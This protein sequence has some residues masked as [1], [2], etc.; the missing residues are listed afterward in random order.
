M[1]IIGQPQIIK[2]YIDPGTGSM[3]F[4]V[5]IGLISALVYGLRSLFIKLKYSIGLKNKGVS[6]DSMPFVIYSEGSRYFNVFYS[7]CEEFE[8]RKITLNYLTQSKDDPIFDQHFSYVKPEFIGSG[9]SGFAKLNLLKANVLLS[10]T[11]GLDVYQWKKSRDVKHY[12]H[13]PHMPNDITTYRMFGLDYYD[14]VLVSGEYQVEQLKKLEAIRNIKKKEIQVVGLTYL[15]SLYSRYQK[16]KNNIKTNNI[17]VLLAPS[18]GKS[19]IFSKY[20]GRIIDNLLKTGFDIIIRPHPQ[21]YISEKEML[22]DLMNQYP[23]QEHLKWNRDIDNFNVLNTSD[24][25][26]SDF[27]GV[28]FDFS[29]VFDKPIIYADTSFDYSPYDAWWLKEPL[30]TFDVLPKIG[31]KLDDE[32]IDSI[33]EL[34]ESTLKDKELKKG[35]TEARKETWANKGES[36][37]LIADY[38][39]EK[40]KEYNKEEQ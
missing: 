33:K 10:T 37:K 38:M 17:T 18:W 31:N 4:T 14:A 28:I 11:P 12:I 35:R 20:G 7:I 27:S 5:L 39:I 36:A 8:K 9:N 23:E 19:S 1:H 3:L 6:N 32:N 29:L 26:I 13:I 2:A 24:I 22:D 21:S 30:W 15:D 40:E 25:L 16:E 34:I